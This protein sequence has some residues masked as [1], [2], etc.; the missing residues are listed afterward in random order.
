MV[1]LGQEI[2]LGL[3]V[4][5]LAG[6]AGAVVLVFAT[7]LF[8]LRDA[9]R[10]QPEEVAR[11]LADYAPHRSPRVAGV[12]AALHAAALWPSLFFCGGRR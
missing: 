10:K 1:S 7:L 4:G 11:T 9:R 5:L 2:A 8:V 6:Y 12:L 3:A